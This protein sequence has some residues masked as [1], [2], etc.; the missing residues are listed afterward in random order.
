[1]DLHLFGASRWTRA[2]CQQVQVCPDVNALEPFRGERNRRR[3]PGAHRCPSH[4]HEERRGV[5]GACRVDQG[6]G[7]CRDAVPRRNEE[8]AVPEGE[9]KAAV[10]DGGCDVPEVPVVPEQCTIDGAPGT[11]TCG[12][13]ASHAELRRIF[14]QAYNVTVPTFKVKLD[15]FKVW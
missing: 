7:G 3:C 8:Q 13:E 6:P 1:M 11:G 10:V 9:V 15:L 14:R 12:H 4:Q 2:V 5:V